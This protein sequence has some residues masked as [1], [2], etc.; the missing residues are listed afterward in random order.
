MVRPK[1]IFHNVDG[2]HNKGVRFFELALSS[3]SAPGAAKQVS[4]V[5]QVPVF[6]Q[7]FFLFSQTAHT[8]RFAP[9]SAHHNHRQRSVV[10]EV[11]TKD[12]RRARHGTQVCVTPPMIDK[13]LPENGSHTCACRP[14]ARRVR[15]VARLGW[16]G[17]RAASLISIALT[18]RGSASSSLP[19]QKTVLR[20]R[21]IERSDGLFSERSMTRCETPQDRPSETMTEVPQRRSVVWRIFITSKSPA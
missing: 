15:L 9:T 21:Q 17:P 6:S 12:L 11:E 14:I 10:R 13:V 19:C 5:L 2:S 4:N 7:F 20:V 8:L 18:K 1:S 16:L 3:K